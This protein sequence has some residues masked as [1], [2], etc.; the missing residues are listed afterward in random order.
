MTTQHQV[1]NS[2]EASTLFGGGAAVASSVGGFPAASDPN[3]TGGPQC[4]Q[5]NYHIPFVTQIKISGTYPVWKD[6]RVSGTFQSYPGTYGYGTG[7]T[8]I[9]WQNVYL[10]SATA[11]SVLTSGQTESNDIQLIEPEASTCRGG[12]SSICECRALSR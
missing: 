12:T 9:N 4:N 3:F 7:A 6:F 8:N 5:Y 2:C 10:S 11:A 1:A